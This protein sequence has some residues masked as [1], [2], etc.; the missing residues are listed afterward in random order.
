MAV[1]PACVWAFWEADQRALALARRSLGDE[2]AALVLRFHDVPALD[3]D[4]GRAA[5][6]FEVTV[7]EMV[8][9]YYY[10]L[11]A[12]GKTLVAELGAR[13]GDDRF[14][15]LA[16]SNWVELP[17][18]GE[19]AA[20]ED[21]RRR[22]HGFANEI[23]RPRSGPVSAYAE[24][25]TPAADAALACA[26]ED[27]EGAWAAPPAP[28]RGRAAVEG[29]GE[30]ASPGVPGRPVIL[31]PAG[32]WKSAIGLSSEEL[33]RWSIAARG[34]LDG[35]GRLELTIGAEIIIHGRTRPDAE[36]V[37]GGVP[38]AVRPD[39]TFELRFEIPCGTPELAPAPR[40]DA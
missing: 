4:P 24:A 16:R 3:C 39:G 23:W 17:R 26:A 35:D 36:V 9:N 11:P 14:F 22:V 31:V 13:S 21:R 15:R 28:R 34:A 19:A 32:D 8:G 6:T 27:A 1:D 38:A 37:I 18:E 10:R 25:R 33:A 12:P 5:Q 40:E 7:S 2:T 29:A 20:Y 30:R